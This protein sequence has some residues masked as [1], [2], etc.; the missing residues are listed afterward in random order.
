M[1]EKKTTNKGKN[2]ESHT[3]TIKISNDVMKLAF[4]D[5]DDSCTVVY[6]GDSLGIHF[7]EA[8]NYNIE[9]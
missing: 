7:F 2:N 3:F 8:L 5:Q 4:I 1:D 9:A 6:G